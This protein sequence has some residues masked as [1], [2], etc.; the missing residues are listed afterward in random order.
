[1]KKNNTI[2][3]QVILGVFSAIAATAAFVAGATGSD[4]IVD[5]KKVIISLVVFAISLVVA[6]RA[7]AI[8][9]KREKK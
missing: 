3:L 7:A 5:W 6:A 1:M 2:F 9:S 8:I 4:P